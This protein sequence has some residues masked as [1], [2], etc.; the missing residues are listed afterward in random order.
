VEA[1]RG[2]RDSEYPALLALQ[3][4]H[5]SNK[6]PDAAALTAVE[7]ALMSAQERALPAALLLAGQF[8]WLQGDSAGAKLCADRVLRENAA[9]DG[10]NVLRGWL[11][12]HDGMSTQVHGIGPLLTASSAYPAP[13]SATLVGE[14][15]SSAMARFE[16][17]LANTAP[18]A[19]GSPGAGAPRSAAATTL[20]LDASMGLALAYERRGD[21]TAAVDVLTDAL[22]VHNWFL[23]AACEQARLFTKQGDW[24]NASETVARIL[25]V[26]G[27]SIE[28]HRLLCLGSLLRE[29]PDS[30]RAVARLQDLLA[31]LGK[32]E[33]RSARLFYDTSRVMARLCA[34]SRPLLSVTLSMVEA[35]CK[36]DPESSVFVSEMA[37]QRLAAGDVSAAATAFRDASRLDETN[38]DAVTGM[39]ACQMAQGL[40][41]EAEA[42][43]ELF[44]MIAGSGGEGEGEAAVLKTPAAAL[45]D[46]Q[47]AWRKNRDRRGQVAYIGEALS[48]WGQGLGILQRPS[49]GSGTSRGGPGGAGGSRGGLVPAAVGE[50]GSALRISHASPSAIL[51]SPVDG[52][53]LTALL[54]GNGSDMWEFYWRLQP[55]ALFDCLRELVLLPG[56]GGAGGAGAG[57]AGAGGGAAGSGADQLL[58]GMLA[59]ALH[60]DVAGALAS[61][62]GATAFST[63]T[64]TSLSS[65]AAFAFAAAALTPASAASGSGAGSPSGRTALAGPAAPGPAALALLASLTNATPAYTPAWLLGAVALSS[66]QAWDAAVAAARRAL[67]LAPSLTDGH[68][69]LAHVGLARGDVRLASSAL[70][71]ALAQ[72]FAVQSSAMYLRI[73]AAVLAAQGRHEEAVAVCE[74]AMRVP[75]VKLGPGGARR[76]AGVAKA[77]SGGAADAGAA[78][79]PLQDRASIFLQLAESLL[80]LDR[81]PEATKAVTDALMEFRGS[82]EEARVTLASARLALKKGDADAALT[83]LSS[84]PASAVSAYAAAQTLRAEVYLTHRRDRRLFLQ[85]YQDVAARDRSEGNL[86]ALGDAHMR[87]QMPEEAVACYE[88]ALALRPTNTP[89]ACKVGRALTLMHDYSRAVTYYSSALAAADAAEAEA[90]EE[91]E[92]RAKAEADGVEPP[93]AAGKGGTS[94][95]THHRLSAT[96]RSMLRSDLTELLLKLRRFDDAR[97]LLQQALQE[98]ASVAT[99]AAA[100]TSPRSR[101][102]GSGFDASSLLESLAA[103]D[104]GAGGGGGADTTA[105]VISLRFVRRNLQLLAKVQRGIGDD[106]GAEAA[107][108]Q[109]HA[110]QTRILALAR[111]D[112]SAAAAATAA[113]RSAVT[114]FTA[115]SAAAGGD[116]STFSLSLALALSHS[117]L[118]A[119]AAGASSGHSTHAAGSGVAAGAALSLHPASLAQMQPLDL[120]RLETAALCLALGRHYEAEKAPPRDE[121]ARELY[122]EAAEHAEG[123]VVPAPPSAPAPTSSASASSAAAGAGASG[124]TSPLAGLTTSVGIGGKGDSGA[125]GASAAAA[126]AVAG[127]D[128]PPS[129]PY[130]TAMLSLARLHLRRGEVEECRGVCNSLIDSNPKGCEEAHVM[131]ADL[132]FRQ[133]DTAA[134]LFHFS[135]LLERRPNAYDALARLVTLLRRGGR[136]PDVLR[137]LRAAV[138]ARPAAEVSD[139][140][141]KFCR[142]LY[143]RYNNEPHE[144]IKLLNAVRSTGEGGASGSGEGKRGRWANLS[145][146]VGRW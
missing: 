100:A 73:K 21:Y 112:P 141:Y 20:F 42:Q 32:T 126:A 69:L 133:A 13:M 39:I 2:K 91:E 136:L 27:T 118:S 35:A 143:L 107:L 144:S 93:A 76:G 22:T 95:G 121:A 85:C 8:L 30:L 110:V 102:A 33:P 19:A 120:E 53:P 58:S 36:Q 134:A 17:V 6:A 81:L 119:A 41:E 97:S 37:A 12:V 130:E 60:P 70:E 47:L 123:I 139:A 111:R 1:L 43:L 34:R 82:A 57:S 64:A 80:A 146:N 101:A 29:G 63:P 96:D 74:S 117:S 11:E 16:G 128:G 15:I 5:R 125:I 113:M 10:A 142:G 105:V 77:G 75:G 4:F 114:G 18:P 103:I 56:T 104:S 24:E 50:N 88:A 137:F 79:V 66:A 67:E 55:D 3:H 90:A 28:C 132:L 40:L 122:R 61:A 129:S 62:A 106:A 26:D 86:I 25:E 94:S 135:A 108:Q 99:G 98:A 140:G 87:V 65:T 72:S 7:G 145:A 14:S 46:A 23:P 52:L 38:A 115:G 71:S 48:I 127:P 116:S 89:L 31:A 44:R 9:H 84:I 51:S 54:P 92:A 59:S 83:L 138:K 109:A 131:L 68:L 49:S 78:A 124:I 45:L